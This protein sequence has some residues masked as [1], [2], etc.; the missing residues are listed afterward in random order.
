MR[1]DD[2]RINFGTI[3]MEIDERFGLDTLLQEFLRDSSKIL[4]SYTHGGMLQVQ[5]RFREG[6]LQP[7]YDDRELLELIRSATSGLFML[8]NVLTKHFGFEEDWKRGTELYVRWGVH[9]HP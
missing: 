5:R 9:P 1:N 4:H 6:D 2:Y 3:G 8:T 7:N